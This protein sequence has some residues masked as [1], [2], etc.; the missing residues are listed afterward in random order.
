MPFSFWF[1]VPDPH[2][3]YSDELRKRMDINLDKIEV[4]PYLPD[5][6]EVRRDIANYYAEVQRFDSKV[7]E[8]LDLLRSEDEL[9]N[10]IV[11]M[12]GDHGW[13]FPR[14]KSK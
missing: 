14:G 11:V 13:P 3:D 8:M 7:G 1:G 10:T 9:N 6:P 12:T 4:P 2:R 5:V